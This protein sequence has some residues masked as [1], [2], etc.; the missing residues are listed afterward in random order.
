MGI[1]SL[2]PSAEHTTRSALSWAAK[3]WCQAW[4]SSRMACHQWLWYVTCCLS[5]LEYLDYCCSFLPA[6]W[7][8]HEGTYMMR[9]VPSS[10]HLLS[11]SQVK[12]TPSWES[13]TGC[14][15]GQSLLRWPLSP[16]C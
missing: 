11:T 12:S 13:F 10:Y 9:P 2:A 14:S 1:V 16:P 15:S 5:S 4:K 6:H 7:V 8:W 3:Q